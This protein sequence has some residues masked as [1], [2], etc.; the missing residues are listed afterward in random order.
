MTTNLLCSSCWTSDAWKWTMALCE[1]R[2]AS[3]LSRQKTMLPART[4]TKT[5]YGERPLSCAMAGTPGGTAP[6]PTSTET[7]PVPVVPGLF[8]VT[9]QS[10]R[11]KG[12]MRTLA[13]EL[14]GGGQR[15]RGLRGHRGAS[16]AA[17]PCAP[18]R[19][20]RPAHAPARRVPLPRLGALRSSGASR[21]ARPHAPAPCRE[22]SRFCKASAPQSPC[23]PL[24]RRSAAWDP[25]R[26]MRASRVDPTAPLTALT[27]GHPC[28][29]LR[30]PQRPK[31]GRQRGW[32]LRW[33]RTLGRAHLGKGGKCGCPE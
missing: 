22:A 6:W 29:V 33:G 25:A 28:P 32:L 3:S 19:A 24:S 7:G 21:A 8:R 2:R 11:H 20:R 4:T 17:P 18:P 12:A 13:P 26:S 23:V 5:G 9:G 1:G 30:D 31:K 15:A 27:S 10:R 16:R 14:A